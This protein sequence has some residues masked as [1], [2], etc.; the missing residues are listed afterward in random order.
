MGEEGGRNLW[1]ICYN[2]L[3]NAGDPTG[4]DCVRFV[5]KSVSG[6]YRVLSTVDD[7]HIIQKAGLGTIGIFSDGSYAD[8]PVTV[9]N[10]VLDGC[11]HIL[12]PLRIYIRAGLKQ[13][14]TSGEYS[15]YVK[16]A[17]NMDG[18]AG[19]NPVRS[20]TI[21]HER[22]HARAY[23]EKI[24]PKVLD[25]L[26]KFCCDNRDTAAVEA[27]IRQKYALLLEDVDYVRT[28]ADMANQATINWY[29]SDSSYEEIT[30]PDQRV[31]GTVFHFDY[32]WR[33][34]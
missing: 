30:P 20:E 2:D 29:R 5:S 27:D 8:E 11:K 17:A 16:H 4:L 24:R 28:S 31:G 21:E 15:G 32:L 22:G 1:V 33:K 6:K 13:V 18:G 12:I 19:P 9:R 14:H 26:D 3:Q 7:I 23:W 10:N 25:V 34:R